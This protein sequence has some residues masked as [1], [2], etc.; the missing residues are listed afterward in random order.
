MAPW[1]PAFAIAVGVTLTATPLLRR[2]ARATGFVDE[3]CV[4][5]SH[6]SP[7]PYLGG[8]GL[9]AA[10]LLA[11]VVQRDLSPRVGV[12]A[13]GAAVLGT[14]G[15]IDDDRHVHPRYRLCAELMVAAAAVAVGLRVH[16]TQAPLVD[17]AITILW[18]V[19]ITNAVNLLDNMDGLAAGVV[20]SAATAVFALAILGEQPVVAAVAAALAGACLAFLPHN[21]RPARIFMGDAGSL[22]L[23]FVLAILTIDVSPALA[24]PVSI[25]IPLLLL[26]LPIVDTTT[27]TIARLRRRRPVVLGG[28]DHLSHRLVMRGFS[29]R[30]AVKILVATQI[31]FGVLAVLAGRKVVGLGW[32]ALAAAVLIAVLVA[33][34]APV[35]VY[36]EPVV[37]IPRR[38]RLLV[39]GA[40]GAGLLLAVPA[41]VAMATTIGPAR[42]GANSA[43]QALDALRAGD[44]ERT[45][46]LFSRAEDSFADARRGLRSPLVSLGLVVPGLASN[47]DAARTMVSLG[48]DLSAAGGSLSRLSDAQRLRA[49]GGALPLEE[50]E[51]LAPALESASRLLDDSTGRIG[52]IDRFFLVPPL[53]RAVDDLEARIT[54][55]AGPARLA[56]ESTRLLPAMTGAGETRRYFLAFQNNAELRGTGGFIGNW[57]E[58]VA[59]G[60]RL[61]LARF[62]RL[63]ELNATGRD[64]R[65]LHMPADFLD[66]WGDFNPAKFWQQ[67]NVSPDFPTTARVIADLY[68]QSGGSPIDGVIAIDPPG[69]AALL[70]LTG[71]VPVPNWPEAVTSD[72]VVEIT[73]KTA[74][75][76]FPNAAERIVF[77][78]DVA[79]RVTEAFAGGD[80][81]SPVAVT[82]ALSSAARA[83]H[84][85][86][87]L[88]RENEQR[89]AV[90]LGVDGAIPPPR[91]DSLTV[92]NQNMAGNKVDYYLRRR[93]EYDVEIEPGRD[94]ASVT[95]TVKV[96]LDNRA[97]STGLATEVIGPYD[98]RFTAGE[99]RT[100]LSVYSPFATRS[101]LVEGKP[102]TLEPHREAGHE[103]RSTVVS[104]PSGQQ[105]TVEA[106]VRGRVKLA[107]G[108]WYR[109]DIGH[110]TSLEP[111]DIRVSVRV[112]EGWR[113]VDTEGFDA[114]SARQASTTARL[115]RSTT[116]WVRMERTGW[117]HV[118]DRL[119]ES[120]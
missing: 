53:R 37:G 2:L 59:D 96:T 47:V 62:G 21:K 117:A 115:E 93:V 41:M 56:A 19:G 9:I 60:G 5:Q 25:A 88:T 86:L 16:A 36:L 45:A 76:R 84:L 32:A 17:I 99:N 67:V 7:V 35:V 10:V 103:V 50:L 20:A 95:G 118:W 79:R 43:K 105:R 27:V 109:L 68:P 63:E 30:R 113:I 102:T 8:V 18:V 23:G 14:I 100:H 74:Y 71:P 64:T 40:I 12:I 29:R 6:R 61:R 116:V 22:F 101:L 15:L 28:K 48:R 92:V 89:L 91:G 72:N 73:L 65:V 44:T 24:P 81:G 78:G 97:P 11:L 3:R 49:R 4:G 1:V 42:A 106:A 108:G 114:R 77:L 104:I 85:K 80:L 38:V 33:V 70:R 112:P 111:D 54:G 39:M 26:A 82:G 94:P 87:Y 110:Q 83:G 57:G 13:F 90:D 52:D 107:P 66:T 58:L 98:D 69:L 31:A 34:T 119:F 120:P 55:E 75:E 51:R 46:D